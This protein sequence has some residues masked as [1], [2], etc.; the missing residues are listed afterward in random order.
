MVQDFTVLPFRMTVQ[1]PQLLVSQPTCVPVSPR[2]SRI[3]CTNSSLGST[4]ASR[5]LPLIVT[6]TDSFFAMTV[7]RMEIAIGRPVAEHGPARVWSIPGS[8]PS[9]IRQDREGQNWVAHLWPQVGQA[10]Q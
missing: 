6:C 3:K 2:T 1:A 7:P 10:G 9:C 4:G 5:R 8:G